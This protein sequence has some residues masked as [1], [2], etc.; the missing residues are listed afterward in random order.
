MEAQRRA[1]P[2]L[3]AGL[4]WG[5]RYRIVGQIGRGGMGSVYLAEDLRLNGKLRALKLTCTLTSESEAFIREAR[6]LADLQHPNLPDIVDY[7]PPDESGWAVLVMEYVPGD[8]LGDVF[9][10]SG[11]RL[12]YARVLRYLEQLCGLLCYLHGRQ[13]PIVFRDLKPSNVLIDSLDRAVLVD[14]GIARAYRPEAA[15][16]TE[17]LGTPAFA[18]PEQLR[19]LQT[20]ARSD[21]YGWGALAYYLLSGG[22]SAYQRTGSLRSELQ[23]EVPAGFLDLLDELLSDNPGMRPQNAET[24][25]R[26]IR[27]LEEGWNRCEADWVHTPKPTEAAHDG[28]TIAAVLSAYPGAGATF[29]TLGLSAFLSSRGIAHAV[30]EFPAGEPELHALL[31]GARRMPRHAAFADPSGRGPA[32][33]AWREAKASLYPANPQG[34]SPLQPDPA[35]GEWLRRLG[36]PLVLLDVSSRWEQGGTAEWLERSGIQS[37]WWVADSHPAKWT[38][39]RQAAAEAIRER[40]ARNGILSGWIA[41]RDHSFPERSE[42]LACF[43]TPPISKL[44]RVPGECVSRTVWTGEGYPAGKAGLETSGRAFQTWAEEVM[45]RQGSERVFQTFAK[46]AT[47]GT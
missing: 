4:V 28:V 21:L 41:N 17:R 39:R 13:P 15:A 11:G 19:G 35:F 33:P 22:R 46:R 43:P 10:R 29:S 32:L 9:A 20:D 34:V 2:A 16:D 1:I 24:L 27:E 6:I 25:K 31:D 36:V 12:P 38:P 7:F 47:M 8:T 45:G 37:L 30:V 42:W 5:D 18:A 14:F 44:H 26:R 3:A 40:A 23:P